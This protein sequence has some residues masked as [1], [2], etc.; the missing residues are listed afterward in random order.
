MRKLF[1]ILVLGVAAFAQGNN[2]GVPRSTFE[3]H[4]SDTAAHSA[5]A[6]NVASRI[7][8]RDGS[9]NFSAGTV[10]V[11]SIT[12]SS[13]SITVNIVGNA[14]TATAL[15]VNPS[16]C[17]SNQYVIDIAA[18]GTLSCSAITYGQISGTPALP[19][20]TTATTSQYFSAYN[21]TT[22]AFTKSTIGYSDITGTLA[23]S[24]LSGI[25]TNSHTQIDTHIAD[26]TTPHGA[27]PLATPGKIVR[28]DADGGFDVDTTAATRNGI[29]ILVD[30]SAGGT[31]PDGGAFGLNSRASGPNDNA[32][33]G[34]CF[35]DDQTQFCFGVFSFTKSQGGV[36]VY[37]AVAP[38]DVQNPAG[39]YSWGMFA[40]NYNNYGGGSFITSNRKD[41]G[42]PDTEEVLPTYPVGAWI[43]T[44]KS[45]SIP[46][47]VQSNHTGTN[48][49][50]SGVNDSEAQVFSVNSAGAVVGTSFAGSGTSLTALNASNLGSGTVPDARFPATLPALSGVNLTALNASNLGSGTVP[51]ARFPATLPV[52]SG[53]NLTALNASNL[54]SGTVPD[55]RFPATLPAASGINLT[56]LNGSNIASGTVADARLSANV[57]LL[58]S[59]ISG[60]ELGNPA[61]GTK[62]GV[63]A[64]TCTGTDK[65]SA[66]GTD[67][68]PVCSTDSTGA[69]GG[70]TTLGVSGSGQTGATQTISKTNDTNVT[71]TLTSASNDHNFALGW[72][73]TLAK[74]R[75]NSATVYNDAANTWST[76]LQDFGAAT[77]KL[78]ASAGASPAAEGLIALD[79]TADTVKVHNGAAVKTLAYTDSNITGSAASLTSDGSNCGGSTSFALGVDASGNGQCGTI[80]NGAADGSTKGILGL[81]SSDFDT[82]SGIAALDY[83]NAQAASATLKGFLTSADWSTFNG[84]GD[85]STN[86]STSVDGET[87]LF[88]STTGKSLKRS[89]LTAGVVKSASGILS[90]AAYT[91]VVTLFASGSCS[92]FLKSDGTCSTPSGGGDVVTNPGSTQTIQATADVVGLTVTQYNG[93]DTTDIF[94]VRT[95]TPTTVFAV[96]KDGVTN[97]GTG[98][99]GDMKIATGACPAGEASYSTF[100]SDTGDIP[101]IRRGT[102]SIIELVDRSTAQSLTNKKL[103]SLTTNGPVYTTAG[104]G[105]LNS[106]TTFLESH[107]P[108]ANKIRFLRVTGS[109]YT[110]S[111]NPA[112]FSDV[113]GL[114]TAVANADVVSFECDLIVDAA[115][116]TTGTQFGI[117]SGATTS[118]IRLEVFYMTSATAVATYGVT[119]FDATSAAQGTFPVSSAGTTLMTVKLIG[120]VVFTSSGTFAIR[121][122]SEVNS[123]N[124]TVYRGSSCRVFGATG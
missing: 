86:T 46:L 115:A 19:A 74:A 5:T 20:N 3:A 4:T 106:A 38:T 22:G 71:M 63:E 55:A 117:N 84:K 51:D 123:S 83:T 121:G 85:A 8:L 76:G 95:K 69:G 40:G 12:V 78:P 48:A 37:G 52:A 42:T 102:G 13:G 114:T 103:G 25:G 75:Q 72:T 61:V 41:D 101:S 82:S 2:P 36:G 92:G 88:N 97:I 31:N 26:E 16:P 90:L 1:A 30:G 6:A 120:H 119:T 112:A 65:L 27:T 87:V 59:T 60:S 70:I 107:I 44:S 33:E 7:V 100:C 14:T 35:P 108:A 39:L 23:H 21:S 50:I 62:G 118:S 24:A 58:G 113:T 109:D 9:G 66:I 104:D 10:T 93:T 57:S 73:G 45:D 64:K 110:N 96:D 122:K 91:D 18:N 94:R 116:T 34:D 32:I 29:N 124:I 28:R 80:Q 81:N 111:A 15:A 53:V 99:A 89:T 68:V 47:V 43:R 56:A 54:G 79:T 67:G 105:T 49:L 17:G 77:F 98:A 11:S